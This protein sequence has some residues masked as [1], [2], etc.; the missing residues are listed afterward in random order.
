[1]IAGG[2]GGTHG[3][4]HLEPRRL[5]NREKARLQGFPDDFIFEHGCGP[6]VRES[7]SIYPRVRRQV[8]NAVPPPA[9]NLIVAALANQLPRRADGLGV[10]A[11]FDS[12]CDALKALMYGGRVAELCERAGAQLDGPSADDDSRSL[13]DD[14]EAVSFDGFQR[15]AAQGEVRVAAPDRALKGPERPVDVVGLGPVDR[16]EVGLVARAALARQVLV[17]GRRSEPSSCQ[18]SS[19][20]RGTTPAPNSRNAVRV[21][22]L[23]NSRRSA[24]KRRPTLL[25]TSRRGSGRGGAEPGSSRGLSWDRHG[26]QRPARLAV[27]RRVLRGGG[28][29]LPNGVGLVRCWDGDRHHPLPVI[30]TG[31]RSHSQPKIL[32]RLG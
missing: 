19:I 26:R 24:I 22:L 14:G 16:V 9:A 10:V 32:G 29:S 27:S 1:M 15:L 31:S 30:V 3:Y 12:A 17:L 2:G 21:R 20:S 5:S 4:H 11:V 7:R 25:P 28:L 8:G 23:T 13:V 18:K 6:G